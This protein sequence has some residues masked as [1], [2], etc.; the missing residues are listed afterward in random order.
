MAPALEGIKVLDL[1]RTLAGPFCTMMLGDMG[2]D[3]IKVEE[4]FQGDETRSWPPFWNGVSAQFLP[5]NRNK[6]DITLNLKNPQAITICLKLAS[7]ADVMVENFRS[8]TVDR[9]GI[10]YETVGSLNPR[11]IY[12]SISGF[13]RTGPLADKP[14]Y[15]LMA[16]AYGGLMSLTGEPGGSPI[17]TGYSVADLFTGMIAYASITTALVARERSGRGQYLEASLLESLVAVMSYHATC[18]LATGQ[19]PQPLGSAHPSVAPYQAFPTSDSYFVLGVAND[20]QWHRFC[21]ALE[22]TGLVEDPRFKHNVD[23]VKHRRELESILSGIFRTRTTAEWINVIE[24]AGVPCSPI[25]SVPDL[26]KDPQVMAREMMVSVPHSQVPELR[27]PANPMN[28]YDT[29]PSVRYP[30]PALG[31]HNLEVLSELGYAE[32][33]IAQ[34]KEEGAI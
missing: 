28:L 24:A 21:Q 15:D 14:G 19:P 32:A 6:R 7:Q 16:Q 12:C 8:G 3:V 5:F 31:E 34:L 23:R 25:N 18:Y 1:T 9:L 20:G 13:G 29:P 26:L 10:G 2:A 11:I 30:P 17:R 22:L 27:M 33:E 4:P